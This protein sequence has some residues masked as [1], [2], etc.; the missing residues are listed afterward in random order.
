MPKNQNT[1]H[2]TQAKQKYLS[3]PMQQRFYKKEREI[4]LNIITMGTVPPG[5]QFLKP[6]K[7]GLTKYLV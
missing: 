6:E 7:S 5:I 1:T 2:N 3:S 4:E